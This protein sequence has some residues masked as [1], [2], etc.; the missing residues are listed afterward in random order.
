MPRNVEIK[1][2]VSNTEALWARVALLSDGPPRVMAQE[3]MFFNV[4]HGRLKLRVLSP[5]HGELI[6]YQRANLAGPKT[7]TYT[8]VETQNPHQLKAVLA[9]ENSSLD[10]AGR[11]LLAP[12]IARMCSSEVPLISR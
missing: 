5:T 1:A 9:I 8:L 7:S 4:P 11:A 12:L 6:F 10:T 2:R 3:D